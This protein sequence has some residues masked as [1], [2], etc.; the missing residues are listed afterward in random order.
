MAVARSTTPSGDSLSHLRYCPRRERFV[1]IF[2]PRSCVPS[3]LARRRATNHSSPPFA[4]FTASPCTASW[5]VRLMRSSR[6]WSPSDI[7]PPS[8]VCCGPL[9]RSTHAL[10]R[11]LGAP[12]GSLRSCG[13]CAGVSAT[14]VS[15]RRAWRR[16][17]RSG[18]R[19]LFMMA[20]RAPSEATTLSLTESSKMATLA[21]MRRTSV[22]TPVLLD[23][24]RT[25]RRRPAPP[26]SRNESRLLSSSSI[27]ARENSSEVMVS[28]WPLGDLE[29]A[30]IWPM[31]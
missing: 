21:R 4:A 17:S 19:R 13:T 29:R 7:P 1:S 6:A 11:L 16:D 30:S 18:S 25:A 20:E 8:R 3:S 24:E 31:K 12:L 14:L 23:A 5:L 26:S 27:C 10:G 9:T 2:R 22:W 28:S 15:R